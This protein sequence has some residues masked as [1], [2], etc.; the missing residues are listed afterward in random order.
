M[1]KLSL[2]LALV[3]ITLAPAFTQNQKPENKGWDDLLPP[4]PG[5]DSV[6]TTCVTCHGLKLVVLGR[7]S[8]PEWAKAVNDMI[9]RGAPVFPDEIEPLVQYLSKSFP[10]DLP[11]PVNVNTATAA[12]LQKIPGMK[13]DVAT[14][15]VE[16]RSKSGP[17][18]DSAELQR[19]AGIDKSDFE[20]VRYL[21]KYSE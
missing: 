5:R 21:L 11:K 18:K 2:V 10:A 8:P 6:T 9:Q 14:H 15:I 13:P 16:A 4:G 3:L 7:K 12:E 19:A 20:S 17:F 1:R